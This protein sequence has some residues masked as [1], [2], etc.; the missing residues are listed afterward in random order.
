M[1][2]LGQMINELSIERS[3]MRSL[4]VKFSAENCTLC[5]TRPTRIPSRYL[6]SNLTPF[7]SPLYH[8][9]GYSRDGLQERWRPRICAAL[10]TRVLTTAVLLRRVLGHAQKSEDKAH[11]DAS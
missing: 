11:N 4:K 8:N 10:I 2:L 3:V 7:P 6:D 9:H 1:P 5:Y